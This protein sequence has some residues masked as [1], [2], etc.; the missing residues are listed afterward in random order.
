M[1]LTAAWL[2]FVH[3]MFRLR[4]A[5]P[6][7]SGIASLQSP[8]QSLSSRQVSGATLP[9]QASRTT[10]PPL[11]AL[12]KQEHLPGASFSG[13]S[14]SASTVSS[15]WIILASHP[16]LCFQKRPWDRRSFNS[17]ATTG[18][19]AAGQAE[20]TPSRIDAASGRRSRTAGP[21]PKR[22]SRTGQKSARNRIKLRDNCCKAAGPQPMRCYRTGQKSARNHIKLRDNGCKVFIIGLRGRNAARRATDQPRLLDYLRG[23]FR[24]GEARG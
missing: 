12:T 1:K 22:C 21:Q 20:V 9:P 13:R 19:S 16:S 8:F 7:S 4:A 23:L 6:T 11:L 18:T 3:A 17:W 2:L 24:R 10:A 14:K 15:W 5:S